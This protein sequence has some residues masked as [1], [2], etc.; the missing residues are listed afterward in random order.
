MR[1]K[2][3]QN[4]ILEEFDAKQIAEKHSATG[5]SSIYEIEY[6]GKRL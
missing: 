2:E 6:K 4:M 1:K 5:I 3:E